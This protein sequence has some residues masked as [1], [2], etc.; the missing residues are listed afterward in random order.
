MTCNIRLSSDRD[1]FLRRRRADIIYPLTSLL[2]INLI[3]TRLPIQEAALLNRAAALQSSR[4]ARVVDI[5]VAAAAQACI[6]YAGRR[7]VRD[8]FG[9]G[10]LG[11]DAAGVDGAG[12]AGLGQRVVARVEVL[13]LL[14]VLG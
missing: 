6:A 10:M 8:V 2:I 4:A 11:A 7:Q 1:T 14:E 13:A 9:E 3:H 12:F 5:A